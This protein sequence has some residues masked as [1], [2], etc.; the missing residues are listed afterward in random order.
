M[1]LYVRQLAFFDTVPEKKKQTRREALGEN[2]LPDLPSVEYLSYLIEYLSELGFFSH[3]SMG[4]IPLT[5]SDIWAWQTLTGTN[6]SCRDSLTIRK[7]S[8]HYVAERTRAKDRNALPP[9]SRPLERAPDVDKRLKSIFKM[10]K[11]GK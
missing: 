2:K 10:M 7:L 5:W 4:A 9:Y 11:K 6:L 8:T 3:G 1:I